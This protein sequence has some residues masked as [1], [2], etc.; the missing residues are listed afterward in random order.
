MEPNAASSPVPVAR[1]ELRE[2]IGHRIARLRVQ[3]GWTQQDV[4][5]RLA[6]SRT[7][8]SHLEADMA[9]PSERTVLLLAG[10]FHLEPLELVGETLYPLQK[11]ERLPRVVARYTEID[12]Q[13]R[14]REPMPATQADSW[15]SQLSAL[16]D[17]GYSH[18]DRERIRAALDAL[19]LSTRS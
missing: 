15:R 6:L 11:A 8:V 12:L 5:D 14:V 1:R 13:L 19:L 2:P 18:A 17:G 7:A 16:L 4:A 10:L 9:Q 3:R